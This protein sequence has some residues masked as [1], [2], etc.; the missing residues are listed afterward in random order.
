MIGVADLQ[1]HW[2]RD[3]IK[4]PGFEDHTTR[5][6]WMQ[7]GALFADIRVPLD[8]PDLTRRDCLA[9]LTQPELAQLLAAE[10]FAGTITVA[11]NRCTWHREINWH[12]EPDINDIGLM[13]FEDGALIEDGVLAEY[14][15]LWRR[16]PNEKLRGHRLTFGDQRAVLIENHSV[17]LV[18]VGPVPQGNTTALTAHLKTGD[19]SP[20]ALRQHFESTYCM[21]HWD[22]ES[23][24]AELATNPFCEGREVLQRG[25][26]F[27][28]SGPT[29]DGETYA[30]VLR[31][32]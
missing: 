6:H 31:A 18:A 14:R 1:G 11:E 27:H 4:A 15:E 17:F 29:F 10:G 22:G 28:W 26:A 25:S 32:A 2:Q 30:Q 9:D 16:R 5:V 24:I 23:G 19:A 20:E 8:R 13:S 7:A 21:G 3:W 12:E